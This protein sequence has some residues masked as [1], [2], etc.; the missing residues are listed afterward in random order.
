MVRQLR[1]AH[2]PVSKLHGHV[3]S[4]MRL[5]WNAA[6]RP[7]ATG[8][9]DKLGMSLLSFP[10][11]PQFQFIDIKVTVRTYDTTTTVRGDKYYK[12]RDA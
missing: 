2:L 12:E 3:R 1:I 9:R 8:R 6:R 10:T 7:S 4:S 5:M 11:D